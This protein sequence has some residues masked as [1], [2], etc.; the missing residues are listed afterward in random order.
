MGK[1]K[2]TV[3][4]TQN[5]VVRGMIWESDNQYFAYRGEKSPK[6]VT[7]FVMRPING[8]RSDNAYLMDIEFTMMDGLKFTS[9]LDSSVF[10]LSLIHI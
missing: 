1:V 3:E 9:Q 7:N 5:Y 10:A 6:E 2:S 8:I 4:E